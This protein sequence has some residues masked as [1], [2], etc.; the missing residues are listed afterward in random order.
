MMQKRVDQGS[1][2][3][4]CGRMDDQARGLVHNEEVLVFEY[5]LERDVLRFVVRAFGFRNCETEVLVATDLG[6]G[7]ADRWFQR[8]A[9]NQGFDPLARHC[10]QSRGERTVE[11]PAG[12]GRLQANLDRLMSPHE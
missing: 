4:A 10:G 11:P 9:A 2:A 6:R 7:V 3:V 1:V 8:T 5:D 12:V